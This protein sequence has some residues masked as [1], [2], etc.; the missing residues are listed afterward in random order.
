MGLDSVDKNAQLAAESTR[1]IPGNN[2]R[3]RR[4][5]RAVSFVRRATRRHAATA[6]GPEQKRDRFPW[7]GAGGREVCLTPRT[8]L[9]RIQLSS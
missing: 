7:R 9:D 6:V 1:G 8:G 4:K 3:T 5:S 2:N